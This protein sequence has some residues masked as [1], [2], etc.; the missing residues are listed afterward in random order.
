MALKRGLFFRVGSTPQARVLRHITSC[1]QA[2]RD[3]R[4]AAIRRANV[5]SF[6]RGNFLRRG[7]SLIAQNKI[8]VPG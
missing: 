4:Y 7:F 2:P 1:S 5:A 8:V 3:G 6:T